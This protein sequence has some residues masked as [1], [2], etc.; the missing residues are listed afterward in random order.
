MKVLDKEQTYF[1]VHNEEYLLKAKMNKAQFAHVMGVAP[2]NVNK[3]IATKNALTL[4]KVAEILEVPLNELL[5]GKRSEGERKRIE[6]CIFVD[7]APYVI[8]SKDDMI[9]LLTAL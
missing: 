7:G 5:F 3:L 4:S 8:K 2:Q 9:R 1:E 6:G